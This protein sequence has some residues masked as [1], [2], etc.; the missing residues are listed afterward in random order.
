MTHGWSPQ[1]YQRH[2]AGQL[3]LGRELMARLSLTGSESVLDI[4]CGDGKV[5]AELA[6]LVPAG[7]VLGVDSSPKMVEFAS[8]QFPPAD[9]PNLSFQVMDARRLSP[10]N[11][12]DLVFSNAC[13]HWVRDHRPVLEGL[14]RCLKPGGRTMIQMGGAG[15]IGP[16]LKVIN[17]LLEREA[18]RGYFRDFTFPWGFHDQA[19][20][21]GL[22]AETSLKALRVE[23]IPKTMML[24]GP[25]ELTAWF[26]TTWLPYTERLPAK[27]R[28]EFLEE[29]AQEYLREFPADH[30]GRIAVEM[31]RLEVEAEK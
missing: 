19:Y 22:L 18:W 28:D 15:N 29:L 6:A 20:Y 13:L 12:Y 7:R 1:D 21:L 2:S 30:E 26:R 23:L 31:V 11:A 8:S 4:G 14:Q 24:D 16:V 10:E 3:T 9:Y 5:T 27:R 25:E 17:R